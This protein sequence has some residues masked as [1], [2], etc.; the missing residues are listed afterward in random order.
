MGVARELPPI[1][2]VFGGANARRAG[3]VRIEDVSCSLGEVLDLSATGLR[4]RCTRRPEIHA[5]DA[6]ELELD[7][8]DTKIRVKARIA[9]V[10]RTG[11]RRH[12]IGLEFIDPAPG[13]RAALAALARTAPMNG[14]FHRAPDMRRSA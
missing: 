1:P 8:I 14:S 4:L 9:W 5:G 2:S 12:E 3:R 10:R 13:T 11:L 6:L 7:G